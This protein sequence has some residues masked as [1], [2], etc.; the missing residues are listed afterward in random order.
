MVVNLEMIQCVCE[1][2][3]LFGINIKHTAGYSPW[4]S[5]V[6]ECNHATVDLIL[7]K[8]LEDLPNLDERMALQYCISV[9]NCCMYIR[10]YTQLRLLLA[11]PQNFHQRPK[12]NY[13]H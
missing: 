6:N 10:G 12:M 13:Q 3:N 5:G 1:L 9:K 8:M 11:K 4:S 2:G 7:T